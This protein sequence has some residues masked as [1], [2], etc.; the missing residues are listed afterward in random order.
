MR[1]RRSLSRRRRLGLKAPQLE[2]TTIGAAAVAAV[3]GAAAAAV[4]GAIAVYLV[5]TWLLGVPI[6]VS[7]TGA[8]A[9]RQLDVLK[10]SLAVI[11]GLGAAVALALNYLRHRVEEA[12][13]R[14]DDQRLFTERF[15]S[16]AEHL[17]HAQPAVRLAGVHALARLADD[18][19]EQRQ[20]CID[21]LCAY[22]RLPPAT[23]EAQATEQQLAPGGA[24]QPVTPRGELEVRQTIV[25]LIT[26]HLSI[27]P[28]DRSRVSWR[29]HDFD[30]TGAV[31]DGAFSF[32]GA[33]FS[34]GKVLFNGATFSSGRVRF[35]NAKFS[36]GWVD[37]R[38]ATFSG[39]TVLFNDA[40]FSGG[41]IVFSGASFSR[42]SHVQF[43]DATFA[44]GKVNFTLATFAG[45]DV[46]FGSA[47]FSGSTVDFGATFSG[48]SVQFNNA[49]FSGGSV[50]FSLARF[51]GGTVK[52]LTPGDWSC[53]PI[54]DTWASPPA[55]LSLPEL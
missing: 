5:L 38:F 4:I 21:V 26:A 46:Y 36:G 16:A 25:R 49:K 19:D 53:P 44:G 20:M 35:N 50:D 3:T 17:G 33:T 9:P 12:D 48:G 7:G 41:T 45:G 31:F 51:D 27:K 52:F 8:H 28:H 34:G 54:F 10:T 23:V 29:G 13:S 1:G 6:R 2:L 43:T 42:G 40:T 18:W 14:R 11:A 39:S 15:E 32:A 47:R 24:P 22:V 55:G 37:F 30:F